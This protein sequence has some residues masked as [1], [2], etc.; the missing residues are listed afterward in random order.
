MSLYGSSRFPSRVL[1]AAL[2]FAFLG[3]CE[4]RSSGSK[5]KSE[6]NTLEVAPP[7]VTDEAPWVKVTSPYD[8]SFD[9]QERIKINNS[10]GRGLEDD[11]FIYWPAPYKQLLVF[12]KSR[13]NTTFYYHLDKSKK[14][15]N[16]GPVHSPIESVDLTNGV[17]SFNDFRWKNWAACWAQAMDVMEVTRKHGPYIEFFG[18]EAGMKTNKAPSSTGAFGGPHESA[19]ATK[20]S[21][22][23][24]HNHVKFNA[25]PWDKALFTEFIGLLGN[26]GISKEIA[27]ELIEAYP[28]AGKESLNR[29]RMDE[30]QS[31]EDFLN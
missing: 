5:A 6:E 29:P 18:S 24:N 3:A 4:F 7:G 23:T 15:P 28:E 25:K 14:T 17:L 20:R 21:Y 2:A 31:A 9:S 13:R 16:R 27:D 8:T 22:H 30:G 26:C 10:T 11:G 12:P 19:H 1:S